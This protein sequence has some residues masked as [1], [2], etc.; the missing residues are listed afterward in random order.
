[1]GLHGRG[2]ADAA[3]TRRWDHFKFEMRSHADRAEEAEEG[4]DNDDV[5]EGGW[6]DDA[7]GEGGDGDEWIFW[8]FGRR[9]RSASSDPW[10]VDEERQELLKILVCKSIC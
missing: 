2:N 6:Y 10:L 9:S 8:D 3:P 5:G 1:M 7:N 4:G